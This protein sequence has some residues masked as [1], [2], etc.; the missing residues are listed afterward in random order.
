MLGSALAQAGGVLGELA[1]KMQ[2][3]KNYADLSRAEQIMD[4]ARAA[5]AQEMEG[6]PES[7]W[8]SLW[9]SKFRPQAQKAIGALGLSAWTQERVS[10]QFAKFDSEVVIGTTYR[11]I[12]TGLERDK[13]DIL[14]GI[15]RSAE[16]G[17]YEGA[18][19]G[20][21]RLVAGHHITEE[22]GEA[23]NLDL[24]RRARD[25]AHLQSMNADP[26][27]FIQNLDEGQITVDPADKIRLRSGAKS[28]QRQR[29]SEAGEE[30]DNGILRGEIRTE[31][32]IRQR[33]Q[34]AGLSERDVRSFVDALTVEEQ[35][36]PEGRTAYLKNY[37]SLW[38]RSLDYDP[39]TDP[40]G[41]G[42]LG[43]LRE[44]RSR[45]TPGERQPLLDN[46][47]GAMREGRT[48][49]RQR[50]AG[51]E[52]MI[53]RLAG[54]GLLVPRP[55]NL[56]DPAA[57]MEFETALTEKAAQLKRDART[58]MK[59]NPTADPAKDREWINSEI[60]LDARKAS[61][62]EFSRIRR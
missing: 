17:D 9:E 16:A 10:P 59:Q 14:N 45:V 49:A 57:R 36:S 12:K 54:L 32:E 55:A 43:I 20:V 6:A 4:E 11:A 33:A 3:S 2:D 38:Q 21:A 25:A 7:E 22:K 44:I 23:M 24:E 52:G 37:D 56:A 5:H 47:R 48:A 15:N 60:G 50:A 28:L 61:A 27:G 18:F 35:N 62:R 26:D 1:E 13:Q 8:V 58:W 34:A 31:E 42:G 53:D 30:L 39:A 41:E 51:M 40:E 19:G 46:L 29:Q